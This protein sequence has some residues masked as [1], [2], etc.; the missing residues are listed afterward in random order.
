MK[1]NFSWDYFKSIGRVSY[2]NEVARI[3]KVA[4]VF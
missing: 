4:E 1:L 3:E 2:W